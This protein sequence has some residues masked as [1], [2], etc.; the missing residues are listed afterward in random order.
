MTPELIVLYEHPSWQ[1]PLFSALDDR[2]IAYDA[3]DLKQSAFE[4]WNPPNAHVYFN[5][6]SPSAYTRGNQRA[7]PF[8]HALLHHLDISDARVINGAK[9]F[10][11]ERSKAKQLA[12]LR[13]L[14]IDHPKSIVFND[15]HAVQSD[16]TDLTWPALL[17]PEQ[18]GSGARMRV[19]ESPNALIERLEEEPELWNPEGLLLVQEL[20]E[21]DEDRG[22]VRMEFLDGELLYAMRVVSNG[23]FNLCPSEVCNP[24]EPQQDATE[25]IRFHPFP[26]VPEEAVET[27]QRIVEAAGIDVG[28]VEYLE[29]PD[30]RR[31]YYDVNANSNLRRP[32]GEAFGFDPFDR[33]AAYLESTI[34][35]AQ[36]AGKASA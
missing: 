28:A 29:T 10:S 24:A 13:H 12:L 4:T 1:E 11:V 23:A 35:E 18:G 17:K 14:G 25:D 27:G 3:F 21:Y 32:I 6:A 33:V 26:D 8:T 7:V 34:L 16:A 22:I 20:L 15:P 5:Q 30:G 31:V 36:Q 2:G 19:I 9:A